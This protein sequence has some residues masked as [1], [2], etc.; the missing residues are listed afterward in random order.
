M[1]TSTKIKNLNS[2]VDVNGNDGII[3]VDIG[4]A[5]KEVNAVLKKHNIH[6]PDFYVAGLIGKSIIIHNTLHISR[7]TN[8]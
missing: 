8:A 4:N 2:I 1:P 5:I 7:P 3:D 6:I